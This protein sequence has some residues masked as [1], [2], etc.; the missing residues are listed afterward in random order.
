M[1]LVCR[2]LD[3]LVAPVE[4]ELLEESR[5]GAGWDNDEEADPPPP[6]WWCPW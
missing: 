6:P 2:A 5:S 1:V 4:V 3:P